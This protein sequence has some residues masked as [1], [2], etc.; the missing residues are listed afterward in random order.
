[1]T[2]L[3]HVARIAVTTDDV[4]QRDPGCASKLQSVAVHLSNYLNSTGSDSPKITFAP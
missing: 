1:M 3:T 2:K 4:K